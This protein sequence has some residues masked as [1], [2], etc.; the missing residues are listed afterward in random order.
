MLSLSIKF[1]IFS[2]ISDVCK[3]YPLFVIGK[4]LITLGIAL[5][6][7]KFYNCFFKELSPG[8]GGRGRSFERN[9]EVA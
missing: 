8:G 5:F 4:F 6:C 1:S 3:K 2:I 7:A 9:F